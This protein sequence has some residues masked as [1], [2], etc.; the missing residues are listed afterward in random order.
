MD[1]RQRTAGR[2]GADDLNSRESRFKYDPFALSLSKG[3]TFPKLVKGK[4]QGFDKLS[5]TDVA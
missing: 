3:C 5:P 1:G 2:E 4:V